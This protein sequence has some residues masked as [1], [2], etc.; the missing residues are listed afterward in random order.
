MTYLLPKKY[1]RNDR[2]EEKKFTVK[3]KFCNMLQKNV[4]ICLSE[5]VYKPTVKGKNL[6]LQDSKYYFSY[7]RDEYFILF[8]SRIF[9]LS[10]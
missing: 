8:P 4:Y 6:L 10:F 9:S 7:R 5:K 2:L 3:R 1:T